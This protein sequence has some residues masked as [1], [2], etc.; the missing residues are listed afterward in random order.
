MCVCVCVCVCAG[1]VSY[2]CVCA[3]A[4]MCMLRTDSTDKILQFINTF[5]ITD[6]YSS[7]EDWSV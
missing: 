3:H 2:V 1:A 5:I 7:S 6:Y 4:C